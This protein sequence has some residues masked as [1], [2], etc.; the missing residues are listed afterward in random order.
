MTGSQI[1][2]FAAQ[3]KKTSI[4]REFSGECV[5]FDPLCASCLGGLVVKREQKEDVSLLRTQRKRC[6]GSSCNSVW[7]EFN[8]SKFCSSARPSRLVIVVNCAA[9]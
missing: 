5:Y 2:H 7:K 1:H 3:A 8:T 4:L 9:T 6:F